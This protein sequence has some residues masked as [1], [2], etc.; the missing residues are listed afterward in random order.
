MSSTSTACDH[1][2]ASTPFDNHDQTADIILRSSDGTAFY[3]HKVILALASPVFR[4]MFLIPQP[5]NGNTQNSNTEVQVVDLTET[6]KLWDTMLRICYPVPNPGV[7]DL[8]DVQ[9]ILEA[10]RKYQ[11]ELVTVEMKRL[12]LLP[13]FMEKFPLRVYALACVYEFTDIARTAAVVSLHHPLPEGEESNFELSLMSGLQYHRLLQYRRKCQRAAVILTGT[14]GL[15]RWAAAPQLEAFEENTASTH[16]PPL[17][18]F[19]CAQCSRIS[20]R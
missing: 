20:R 11:M 5:A 7:H 6:S 14:E 8:V 2:I 10:A 16:S 4:D 19:S 9:V 15:I 3:A 18:L 13:A 17:A 12:L 1:T